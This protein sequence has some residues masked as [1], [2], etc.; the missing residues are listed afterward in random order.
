MKQST[1]H[2]QTDY[3][4]IIVGGGMVGLSV[5]AGLAE[6]YKIALVDSSELSSVIPKKIGIRVSAITR[7]SENWLKQLNA[8]QQI[9]EERLSS[10]RQMKVWDAQGKGELSFSAQQVAEPNLGHIVENAVIQAGLL[11]AISAMIDNGQITLITHQKI[12]KLLIDKDDARIVFEDESK[13]NN[14]LSSKLIIAAD[15]ANSWVRNYLSFPMNIEPYQ[16]SALVA[17][18]ESENSH[19]RTAWQRF[20]P[21]GPLAFLPMK[22]QN[23]HSI[24]WSLDENLIEQQLSSPKDVFESALEEAIQHKFGSL[25]LVSDRAV[26]PLIARHANSYTQHRVVLV[27]DAAHSIHPLAGQGVNLGFKDAKALVDCI[28]KGFAESSDPGAKRYLRQYQRLRMGDNLQVQK[29]MSIIKQGFANEQKLISYLRNM[30]MDLID[31]E[32]SLKKTM[33]KTAMGFTN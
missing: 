3:D 4:I 32:P 1:N 26:F 20:L 2:Q 18:I 17:L 16:Q 22:A 31:N 24:V 33:I 28:K 6:N 5:A 29:S 10:Y 15:G 8:W 30:G 7:G 23:L 11:K 27:G 9:P 14:S 12:E 13:P 25:K 19:Q 21:S